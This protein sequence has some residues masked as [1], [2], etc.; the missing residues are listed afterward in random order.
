MVASA[1]LLTA[2]VKASGQ[3]DQLDKEFRRT[4]THD[5]CKRG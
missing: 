2:K 4:G 5:Q 3:S 1:G